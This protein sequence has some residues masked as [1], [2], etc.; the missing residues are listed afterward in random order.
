MARKIVSEL[1]IE[2]DV[3]VE[4]LV[5]SCISRMNSNRKNIMSWAEVPRRKWKGKQLAK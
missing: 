3:G 1:T 2:G 4:A 5:T